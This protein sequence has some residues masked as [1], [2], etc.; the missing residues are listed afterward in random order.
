M[1]VEQAACRPVTEHGSPLGGWLWF[2]CRCARRGE[3]DVPK[4]MHGGSRGPGGPA[5]VLVL[6][7]GKTEAPG[8]HGGPRVT[9]GAE[10]PRG[11]GPAARVPAGFGNSGQPSMDRHISRTKESLEDML[12]GLDS[13]AENAHPS[14]H[15]M[16]AHSL[17][18]KV[19]APRA[20]GD[21]LHQWDIS[22][23]WPGGG[24]LRGEN[25]ADTGSAS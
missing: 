3:A 13:W 19:Q 23:A 6:T 11:G 9:D 18:D 22:A 17:A 24:V 14:V 12:V 2:P 20:S 4:R 7:L 25:H 15:G 5:G 8:V 10:C 1:G 16:Q 21:P